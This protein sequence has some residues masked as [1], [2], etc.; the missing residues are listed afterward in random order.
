MSVCVNKRHALDESMITQSVEA[1]LPR[2]ASV[3][4]SIYNLNM[5]YTRQ[6]HKDVIEMQM[7]HMILIETS[8]KLLQRIRISGDGRRQ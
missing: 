2:M 5:V 4:K 1:Y 6:L 3:N 8:G 7:G